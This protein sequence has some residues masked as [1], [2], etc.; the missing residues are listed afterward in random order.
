[1]NKVIAHNLS[2]NLQSHLLTLPQL[3]LINFSSSP[4]VDLQT[5]RKPFAVLSTARQMLLTGSFGD[6]QLDFKI[7]LKNSSQKYF[8]GCIKVFG[9]ENSEKFKD[10]L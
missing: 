1:M 9:E 3:K 6:S 5:Q 8:S 7:S 2:L 10:E 4:S